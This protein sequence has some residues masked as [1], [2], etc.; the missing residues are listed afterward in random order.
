MNQ[1][2]AILNTWKYLILSIKENCQTDNYGIFGKKLLLQNYVPFSLI[3][4]DILTF[5]PGKLYPGVGI[6]FPFFDPGVGVLH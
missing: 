5:E 1:Q 4:S 3:S 6:L 2:T